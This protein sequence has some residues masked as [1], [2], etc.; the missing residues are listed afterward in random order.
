[1]PL[2]PGLIGMEYG[3]DR[4]ARLDTRTGDMLFSTANAYA[5]ALRSVC[6]HIDTSGPTTQ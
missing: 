6:R 4:W 1:M 3:L 2:M 5:T